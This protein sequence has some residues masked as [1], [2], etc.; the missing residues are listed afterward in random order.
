MGVDHGRL[1]ALVAEQLLDGTDVVPV[2]KELGRE[3]VSQGVAS[4]RFEDSR[5]A[6]GILEATLEAIGGVM[7]ATHY[8]TARI[9]GV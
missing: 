6:D 3:G 9:A 2:L 8:S 1:D 7:V 4:D 5:P